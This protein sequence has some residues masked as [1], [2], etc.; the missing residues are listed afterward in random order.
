[1]VTHRITSGYTI[2][3]VEHIGTMREILIS[4]LN[5]IGV[6]KIIKA[7]DGIEAIS[8][9]KNREVDLILAEENLPKLNGLELLKYVRNE[10]SFTSVPFV[11]LSA[12]IAHGKIME[13][14]DCGVS[15]YLVKPFNTRILS[16]KLNKAMTIAVQNN[17]TRSQLQETVHNKEAL[18][19]KPT[20]LVVDDIADNIVM[21]NASLKNNYNVLAART[22]KKAISICHSAKQPD[23]ILLDIMMPNIDGF[24]V[25]R[26]LKEDPVTRH[27]EVIFVTSAEEVKSI[28][29][30][31]ELGAVDYI[32]KPIVPA[33]LLARV[34][35]HTRL[36]RQRSALTHQIDS[37]IENSR[38]RDEL[39][40]IVN[41]DVKNT[42]IEIFRYTDNIAADI[43]NKDRIKGNNRAIRN[44]CSLLE[45]FFEQMSIVLAIEGNEYKLNT[46]NNLLSALYSKA[47]E[48]LSHISSEKQL[49]IDITGFSQVKLLCDKELISMAFSNILLNAIQAAPRGSSVSISGKTLGNEFVTSIT[50]TGEIDEKIKS[51]LFN[52]YTTYG[53]KNNSGIGAYA[54]K[55]MIEM[56]DGKIKFDSSYLNQTT[57]FFSLPLNR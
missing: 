35:T 11:M 17:T 20:I 46:S 54:A 23:L 14:I 12:D 51:T 53:K 1:M 40:R 25:C 3:V 45:N 43:T 8:R 22:G 26:R 37:L 47:I 44:C 19:D 27:I 30:G 33:V 6:T 21:I 39:D 49:E 50:N 29:K 9:L 13:A 41:K 31:F 55:L 42:L 5:S 32:T 2:L 4:S 34:E 48:G 52:K 57:F 15:E 18:D 28:I 24:E 16:E 38:V 36:I 10:Q 56:H 7:R